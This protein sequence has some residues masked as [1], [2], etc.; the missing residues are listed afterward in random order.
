MVKLSRNF[1]FAPKIAQKSHKK[2]HKSLANIS[3][4]ENCSGQNVYHI[5]SFKLVGVKYNFR[6]Q[7]ISHAFDLLSLSSKAAAKKCVL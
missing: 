7:K 1:D 5:I 6:I 2:Y 4:N 3:L